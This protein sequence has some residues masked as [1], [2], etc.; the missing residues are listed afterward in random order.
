MRGKLRLGVRSESGD[1]SP[2][3][4]KGA[5]SNCFTLSTLRSTP[6]NLPDNSRATCALPAKCRLFVSQIVF[7]SQIRPTTRRLSDP[8]PGCAIM[9][10]GVS[11]PRSPKVE[12][13]R[14][15]QGCDYD[16]HA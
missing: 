11:A 5:D 8:Q 10:Y 12:P 4:K 6:D 9:N 14:R 2:H 16:W 1:E 13:A 3:S 7:V 15:R